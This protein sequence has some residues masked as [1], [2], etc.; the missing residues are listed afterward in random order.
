MLEARCTT[1]ALYWLRDA[2]PCSLGISARL[3]QQGRGPAWLCLGKKALL[4]EF[5]KCRRKDN[6]TEGCLHGQ[7]Q[8]LVV[9]AEHQQAE[10]GGDVGC[11]G[12]G[13]AQ[14]RG[15]W[16]SSLFYLLALPMSFPV[17]M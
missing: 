2:V 12:L 5:A 17:H 4:C 1:D 9:E 8:H 10:G 7:H 16:A 13:V 15:G 11:N 14:G 6:A 3:W